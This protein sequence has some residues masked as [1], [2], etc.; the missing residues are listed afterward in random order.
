MKKPKSQ[1]PWDLKKLLTLESEDSHYLLEACNNFP[2]AI[3]LLEKLIKYEGIG[4]SQYEENVK[5]FL[6]QLNS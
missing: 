2:I 1:L 6:K 5:H 3:D 4:V